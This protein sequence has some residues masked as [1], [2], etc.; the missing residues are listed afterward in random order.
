ME[1]KNSLFAPGA[2]RKVGKR[3]RY[4]SVDAP[5]IKELGKDQPG[6]LLVAK[7][8]N[9]GFADLPLFYEEKQISLF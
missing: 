8:E 7:R 6:A 9:R 3:G 4:S 1:N 2:V 5:I